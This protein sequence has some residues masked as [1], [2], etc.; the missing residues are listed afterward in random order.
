MCATE[1]E[2]ILLGVYFYRRV[3]LMCSTLKY[4][5]NQG[6]IVINDMCALDHHLEDRLD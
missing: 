5:K 2:L 3:V 1:V 6:N 4:G